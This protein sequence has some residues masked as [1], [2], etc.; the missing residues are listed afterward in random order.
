MPKPAVDLMLNGMLAALGLMLNGMLAA[1]GLMLNGMLAALGLML[2]GML[3]ALGE[4]QWLIRNAAALCTLLLLCWL[5]WLCRIAYAGQVSTV[6]CFENNP[7]V[8]KV[9]AVGSAAR[10][11][12]LAKRLAVHA[13]CRG[14]GN[15]QYMR[16]MQA[17]HM[18]L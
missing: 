16:F 6:K 2:N 15:R 14:T 4:K 11:I 13:S 17:A 1:L 5:R 12:Q 8:R 10:G 9:G 3:A 18:Q 7:L